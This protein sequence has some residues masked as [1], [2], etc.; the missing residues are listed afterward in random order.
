MS[1]HADL[2]AAR[3]LTYGL[4]VAILTGGVTPTRSSLQLDELRIIGCAAAARALRDLAREM[5]CSGA[6]V[7]EAAQR[8]D[9]AAQ[10]L[11]AAATP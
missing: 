2:H 7:Q 3:E 4:A 8:Y 10:T 1:D 11:R 9:D 6:Q 5:K